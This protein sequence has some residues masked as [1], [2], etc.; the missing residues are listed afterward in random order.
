[1]IC[2]EINDLLMVCPILYYLTAIAQSGQAYTHYTL[3]MHTPGTQFSCIECK[4]LI[5]KF[6]SIFE[7]LLL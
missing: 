1:M 6:Y 3:L 5:W 2:D 7:Q 4:T